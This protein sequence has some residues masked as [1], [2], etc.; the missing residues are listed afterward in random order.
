MKAIQT[1]FIAA[2][3]HSAAML[4]TAVADEAESDSA[5]LTSA[6]ARDTENA[7]YVQRCPLFTP[8]E[9]SLEL[10]VKLKTMME[11]AVLESFD[12]D[13]SIHLNGVDGIIYSMEN[14][15]SLAVLA[16]YFKHASYPNVP[17]PEVLGI[18][19]GKDPEGIVEQWNYVCNLNA[20]SSYIAGACLERLKELAEKGNK[21]A[22]LHIEYLRQFIAS[23]PR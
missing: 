10:I 4:P 9:Q 16:M 12:S 2:A 22:Q 13:D 14:A 1:L 17:S 21:R 23:L 7:R 5:A 6:Q 3:L 20:C 8:G 15:D 18:P 11:E 19:E